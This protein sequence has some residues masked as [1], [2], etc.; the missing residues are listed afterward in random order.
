MR[1]SD[2]ENGIRHFGNGCP[3]RLNMDKTP[4]DIEEFVI[5]CAL[6]LGEN[7]LEPGM[8]A[9]A[10]EAQDKALLQRLPVKNLPVPE[11]LEQ[12]GEPDAQL[13]LLQH[14]EQAGHRPTPG[15]LAFQTPQVYRLRLRIKWTES[16]ALLALLAQRDVVIVWQGLVEMGECL[17]HLPLHPGDERLCLHRLIQGARV[18]CTFVRKILGDILG[19]VTVPVGPVDPHLLTAQSLTQRLQDAHFVM[20]TVDALAPFLVTL[21]HQRTQCV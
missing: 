12:T 11:S 20:D 10:I 8:G 18:L 15:N 3:Q 14:V 6:F 19:W 21:D 13:R 7:P 16:D 2:S 5:G 9:E 4:L 1:L 17:A